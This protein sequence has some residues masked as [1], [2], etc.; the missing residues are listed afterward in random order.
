MHSTMIVCGLKKLNM[1]LL[2]MLTVIMLVIRTKLA[3]QPVLPHGLI[4]I[5][6][7]LK[8]IANNYNYLSHV[9]F[10]LL[11]IL[12]HTVKYIFIII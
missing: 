9:L 7:N 10:H 11:S 5:N 6:I 2:F 8:F 12:T 4:R 1:E 3:Y